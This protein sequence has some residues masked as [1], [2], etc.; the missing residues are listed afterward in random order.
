MSEYSPFDSP[1]A[2]KV[3]TVSRS[4]LE[5]WA[6]CPKRAQLL[7]EHEE[8]EST[9]AR[10]GSYVHE[11][12]GRIVRDFIDHEKSY[13]IRNAEDLQSELEEALREAPPDIQPQVL[14]AFR[15]STYQWARWLSG[16]NPRNILRF[17]GGEGAESGQL[18]AMI[19]DV[20]LTCEMD[21]LLSTPSPQVL[22][23]VDWKS[24]WKP[25]DSQTVFDSFQ[26]Q[27]YSWI[28]FSNYEDIR[29]VQVDIWCTRSGVKNV[30]T[31]EFSR[32]QMKNIEIRLRMV[33]RDFMNSEEARPSHENCSICPVV[34]R[35]DASGGE[36][37]VPKDPVAALRQL[38]V[39]DARRKTL[40]EKLWAEVDRTGTDIADPEN[41]TA[42]GWDKPTTRKKSPSP[43]Y[44]IGEKS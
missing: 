7:I 11:V 13:G 3:V 1:E 32:S 20:R 2:P 41:G 9:P 26:F 15:G 4:E 39:L 14:K 27:F 22:R 44:A 17:D 18:A 12:L 24:G 10:V 34:L 31:V 21:L 23:I 25:W 38:V 35:C 42:F 37:D 28:V 19:G 5:Q 29:A 16:I 43:T 33:L 6:T 40:H 36:G 30:W 8:T